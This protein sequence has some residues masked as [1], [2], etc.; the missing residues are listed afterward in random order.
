MSRGGALCPRPCGVLKQV[1]VC[2][3]F[4]ILL[5]I[6]YQFFLTLEETPDCA[7]CAEGG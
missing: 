1:I 4:G 3:V 5:Q 6:F 2:V 7:G